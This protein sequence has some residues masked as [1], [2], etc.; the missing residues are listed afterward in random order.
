MTGG[1][2]LR[3]PTQAVSL[4]SMKAP[5]HRA[6]GRGH[7]HTGGAGMSV[8]KLTSRAPKR[9]HHQQRLVR[10]GIKASHQGGGDR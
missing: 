9:G 6:N 2:S 3:R 1:V 5:P 7:G 4:L 8:H 10:L